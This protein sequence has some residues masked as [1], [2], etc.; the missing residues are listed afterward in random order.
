M[1]SVAINEYINAKTRTKKLQFGV[2]KCH[3]LHIGRENSLCHD[4]FIDNWEVVK[5]DP[6]KT[7]FGNLK[8]KKTEPHKIEMVAKDK[9]LGDI[10][11]V[12]GKNLENILARKDKS[13]V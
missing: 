10:I 12:N 5:V 2:E 9:Y 11:S 6:S 1:N 13:K 7:G 8:D 4:L 3:Q